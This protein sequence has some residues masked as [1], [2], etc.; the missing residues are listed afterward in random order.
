MADSAI[1]NP[2]R[3]GNEG[4]LPVYNI[5]SQWLI[6]KAREMMLDGT[7]MTWDVQEVDVHH[8]IRVIPKTSRLG[9]GYR[10]SI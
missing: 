9:L 3:I 8:P 6:E 5:E 4:I 2:F 7:P 10:V 1:T